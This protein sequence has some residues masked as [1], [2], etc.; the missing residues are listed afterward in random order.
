MKTWA[1]GDSTTGGGS[2][3]RET[4]SLSLGIREVRGSG[5]AFDRLASSD[6][7]W[8]QGLE[9]RGAASNLAF[10]VKSDCSVSTAD[11]KIPTTFAEQDTFV[12]Y[13][14]PTCF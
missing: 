9:C 4:L 11:F 7:V 1:Q 14:F 5:G 2:R 10:D 13:Q 3:W 12:G 6:P 8:E